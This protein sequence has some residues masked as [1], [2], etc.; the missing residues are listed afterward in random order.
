MAEILDGKAIGAALRDGWSVL[1]DATFLRRRERRAAAALAAR[2]GAPFH[3]LALD[4]PRGVLD[5]R[6]AARGPDASDATGAVLQQQL[7]ALQPPAADERACSVVVDPGSARDARALAR[8]IL[9]G[10]A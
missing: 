8:R 2:H 5:A 9:G 10:H 4:A 1:L 7:A 3:L 6:L